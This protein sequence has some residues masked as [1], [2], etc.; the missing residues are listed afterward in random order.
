MHLKK[1][2]KITVLACFFLKKIYIDANASEILNYVV[3]NHIIFFKKKC[4]HNC[5]WKKM[6][7]KNGK[8]NMRIFY[9]LMSEKMAKTN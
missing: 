7:V 8:P 5:V 9:T 1:L 3:R 4:R 2:K 6:G